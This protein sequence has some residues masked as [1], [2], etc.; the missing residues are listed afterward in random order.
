MSVETSLSELKMSLRRL[1]ESLEQ[2][3]LTLGDKPKT[4]DSAFVDSLESKL[5]DCSGLILDARKAA[6]NAF[7]AAGTVFDLD[8]L[9]RSLSVAQEEF[10]KAQKLLAAE[11]VSGEW[12]GEFSILT[13]RGGEWL[14]WVRTMLKSLQDCWP[15]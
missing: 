5:M 6:A 2:A 10:R 8:A 15:L 1:N 7:A 9:R 11:F 14:L 12:H 3:T 4:G 13:H